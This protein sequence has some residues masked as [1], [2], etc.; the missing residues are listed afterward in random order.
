[1]AGW[2]AGCLPAERHG[3]EDAPIE[4]ACTCVRPNRAQTGCL[5]QYKLDACQ[6]GTSHGDGNDGDGRTDDGAVRR[7]H[8]YGP[9]YALLWVRFKYSHASDASAVVVVVVVAR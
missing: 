8:F 3:H 1:M 2:L 9:I 5:Q 4:R 6:D 7:E